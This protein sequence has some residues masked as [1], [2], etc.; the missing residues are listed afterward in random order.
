MGAMAKRLLGLLAVLAVASSASAQ[1]PPTAQSVLAALSKNMGADNLK[2]IT[3]GGTVG[4]VGIVGQAYDIRNDWPKVLISKYTRTINYDAKS[5][6]EDRT[7]E[8]GNYP[9]TGGGGIPLQGQQ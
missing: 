3:Y 7:I 2:C 9:R 6:Y 1:T 8:Q 5:S 4:Y